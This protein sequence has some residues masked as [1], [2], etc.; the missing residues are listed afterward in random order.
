[1]VTTFGSRLKELRMERGIRQDDLAELM[2]VTF[3]T[4]SKWERDIRKPDLPMLDKLCK[5]FKVPL[6]Y[7]LG[8]DVPRT[9][10]ETTEAEQCMWSISDEDVTLTDFALSMS[11]LSE[12]TRRIVYAT[13]NAAYK[14]DEAA[15]L[16]RPRDEFSVQI[17]HK[18]VREDSA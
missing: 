15:G 1:M 14:R 11:Q 2:G 7:L 12:E 17:R 18:L 8:E 4:V 6:G 5:E 16:L 13:I 9:V 3:G 10:D